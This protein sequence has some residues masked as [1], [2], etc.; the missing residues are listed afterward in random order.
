[1]PSKPRVLSARRI[2]SIGMTLRRGRCAS[3]SSVL[4]SSQPF[5]WTTNSVDGRG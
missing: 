4:R 5:R 3:V 2:S 1:M